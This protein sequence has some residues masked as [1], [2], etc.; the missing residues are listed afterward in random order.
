MIYWAVLV[1]ALVGYIT[2]G[3]V[4]WYFLT[5]FEYGM[6]SGQLGR[7]P[8]LFPFQ[9]FVE[10]LPCHLPDGKKHRIEF[11]RARVGNYNG[12]MIG[13]SKSYSF[14]DIREKN[15]YEEVYWQMCGSNFSF[16]ATHSSYVFLWPIFTVLFCSLIVFSPILIIS[17]WIGF[18]NLV[19]G[20]FDK[21]YDYVDAK[22]N[23]I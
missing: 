17:K 19:E 16:W 4:N 9:C 13:K 10:H 3:L 15:F 2:I 1:L 20:I 5:G 12:C 18:L 7:N 11:I 14:E 21:I 6:N 23:L 22:V 8:Y